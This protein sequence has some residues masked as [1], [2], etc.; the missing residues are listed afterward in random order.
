[1]EIVSNTL[2]PEFETWDDPGVY[3]SGAG[4]GPLASYK[5]CAGCSGEIVIEVTPEE[6]LS[7]IK[8]DAFGALEIETSP[9]V[10]GIKYYPKPKLEIVDGK[11]RITL[12]IEEC[13][14]EYPEP[15]YD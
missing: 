1:M 13:E 8:E 14:A 2:E 3:P 5:Y 4:S 9:Q 15:D 6:I 11:L 10:S 7:A 12:E